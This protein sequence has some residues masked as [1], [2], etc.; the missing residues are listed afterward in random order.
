MTRLFIITVVVAFLLHPFL[1]PTY[2]LV[3]QSGPDRQ[4]TSLPKGKSQP[5]LL[6][7][8]SLNHRVIISPVSPSWL[9]YF[10]S[11]NYCDVD[12]R[13]RPIFFKM[14]SL[15]QSG[16]YFSLLSG[17][18]CVR[19]NFIEHCRTG[20]GKK[21]GLHATSRFLPLIKNWLIIYFSITLPFIPVSCNSWDF[22][23]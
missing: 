15:L 9:L 16:N 4:E 2:S 20:K 1:W 8:P 12:T 17:S 18:S 13:G 6:T 10:L 22:V 14:C 21:S 5:D 19:G 11:I 7:F 3:D 23:V